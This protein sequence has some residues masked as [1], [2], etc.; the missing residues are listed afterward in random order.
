MAPILPSMPRMPNPPGISTACTS[1]STAAAPLSVSQ[2]SEATHRISTLARCLK[3]P[4]RRAS[5]T[6]RYASERSMYLPTNAIRTVSLAR[7]P[8]RSRSFHCVQSTSRN[9]RLS[10]RTT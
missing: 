8:A 10:R 2:S 9:G 3:P 1:L 7:A 4:A 5:A 6:E